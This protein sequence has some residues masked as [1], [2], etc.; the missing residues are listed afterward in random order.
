[1]HG[2]LPLRVGEKMTAEVALLNKSAVALAADSAATLSSRDRQE[3]VFNTEDKLFEL[4]SNQPIGV[5]IFN[6]TTFMETPIHILIK[7]YRAKGKVFATVSDA[8]SDFRAY[9]KEFALSL[10]VEVRGR[11]FGKLVQYP[12]GLVKSKTLKDLREKILPTIKGNEGL[13]RIKTVAETIDPLDIA[14]VAKKA[15]EF[16]AQTFRNAQPARFSGDLA[17]KTIKGMEK[18]SRSKTPFEHLNSEEVDLICAFLRS[19]ATSTGST[20]FVIAGFAENELFPSLRSFEVDGMIGDELRFMNESA[21]D[22]TLDGASAKV[23]PFAQQE[24]VD[25]FVSGVDIK[26]QDKIVDYCRIQ[27]FAFTSD[28][29]S[30]L[31]I[32]DD[33][34]RSHL[35][36]IL[37]SAA[38]TYI[39]NLNSEGFNVIKK[40]SRIEMEGM[41]EF[42]PK[43]DLAQMAE[44]LVELTS[45]KRRVSRGFETA[46]GPIDVA[47]ISR[48]DGLVWIKRKHYFPAE[49]NPRYFERIRAAT[50]K[51][52]ARDGDD[53]LSP[54][55]GDGAG[56]S[57]A[58][59][60][61]KKGSSPPKGGGNDAGP[62]SPP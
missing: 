24:M 39:S 54:Q 45:I 46:G 17:L 60:G 37:D 28:L 59:R 42:M 15:S 49:L 4:S 22:I 12:L 21:E 26:S 11:D 33:S 32:E 50:L 38:E 43:V 62:Q 13:E 23:L 44:S 41:V 31:D 55:I 25:R 53:K 61:R 56:G 58:R 14:D 18:K 30:V 51:G 9:L 1:M 8:A 5:M 19:G 35:Q 20:G 3:K 29:M 10:D 27:L 48:S 7:K 52:V 16:Y 36:R 57:T 34:E 47:V 40:A 6:S 2:R